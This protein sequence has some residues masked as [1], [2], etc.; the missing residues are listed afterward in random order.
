MP[1]RNCSSGAAVGASFASHA[2]ELHAPPTKR[3]K[4]ERVPRFTAEGISTFSRV[5]RGKTPPVPTQPGGAC[6][7]SVGSGAPGR[8]AE[9]HTTPE[10]PDG[11]SPHFHQ[12][13]RVGV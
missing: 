8:L 4:R 1:V 6:G 11:A 13:F 10:P 9:H 7:L 3:T 5:C 2:G 12:C